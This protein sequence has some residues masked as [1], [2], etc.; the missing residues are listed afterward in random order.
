MNTRRLIAAPAL[1]VAA[2]LAFILCVPGR[3][4]RACDRTPGCAGGHAQGPSTASRCLPEKDGNPRPP[5]NP[6]AREKRRPEE[7]APV[8]PAA[9]IARHGPR[10]KGSPMKCVPQA[11]GPK[12][13]RQATTSG[14]YYARLQLFMTAS[15]ITLQDVIYAEG[16]PMPWA[17]V[18]GD[19]LYVV[20]VGEEPVYADTF[21][22]PLTAYSSAKAGEGHH[23][24]T[25]PSAI[26]TLS[27]P[28]SILEMDKLP[29]A[30][31]EVRRL[32]PTVSY[33][34]PVTLDTLPM[35]LDESEAIGGVDGQTLL[36]FLESHG[37]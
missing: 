28:A 35:L 12:K 9:V 20:W 32:G 36:G 29:S 34:T 16:T 31:V 18:H 30:W 27:V 23:R 24:I 8:D 21:L 13:E 11:S 33:S 19:Y 15:S 7:I 17:T 2:V 14:P 5:L 26:I 3:G 22:D 37:Q 10:A 6:A 1:L 4:A 25:L